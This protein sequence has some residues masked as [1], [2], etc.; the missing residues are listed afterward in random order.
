M[1]GD[2]IGLF[3]YLFGFLF[4]L[5]LGFFVG[6]YVERRHFRQL[7]EREAANKG[8]IVTQLKT[9][10]GGVA[11]GSSA[12]QVFFAETVISSD[13]L[14]TFLSS[15]RKFFGGEMKSYHSLLER[16][17]RESLLRI[18]EQARNAGYDTACNLRYETADLGGAT[19]PK[20][21]IVTVAI[22]ASATAYRRKQVAAPS[23]QPPPTQPPP[24]HLAQA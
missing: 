9:Y 22:L 23:S 16:A 4:M 13:Y 21:R 6:G 15:I 18:I 1:D 24:S 2:S 19:N 17:R 3:V 12:P 8:F 10:P 7:E 20:K 11:Q 14:K 5:G